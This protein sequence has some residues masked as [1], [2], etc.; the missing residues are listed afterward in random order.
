MTLQRTNNML[1]SRSDIENISD[2]SS[3]ILNQ[4]MTPNTETMSF[5]I[6]DVVDVESRTWPGINKP[7]GTARVKSFDS[8]SHSYCVTYMLGG[9]EDGV[10][11]KYIKAHSDEPVARQRRQAEIVN[12]PA[13]IQVVTTKKRNP[14]A[15]VVCE[16]DNATSSVKQAMKKPRKLKKP[17]APSRPL[18][19]TV[20][21]EE[22][23]SVNASDC[24]EEEEEIV[25]DEEEDQE[26]YY[27]A[28][29]SREEEVEESASLSDGAM[30]AFSLMHEALN[31]CQQTSEGAYLAVD[32]EKYIMVKDPSC[33][34]EDVE[35]CFSR[36]EIDNKIMVDGEDDENRCIYVI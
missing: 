13:P 31:Q 2:V 24:F 16:G 12:V 29:E 14:L 8:A 25:N 4:G 9:K 17:T 7:G 20:T 18:G 30:V 36:A 32:I 23:E 27:S 15:N 26:E 34:K 22:T 5:K 19:Y 33:T 11:V 1:Q 35:A 28:E 10:D 21:D 3:N 6:G